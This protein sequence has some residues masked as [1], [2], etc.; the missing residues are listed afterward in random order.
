MS[1]HGMR[2]ISTSLL[3]EARKEMCQAVVETVACTFIALA[4]RREKRV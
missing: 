1:L 4:G 3:F 2:N